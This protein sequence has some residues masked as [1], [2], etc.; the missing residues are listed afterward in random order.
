MGTRKSSWAWQV[1][2]GDHVGKVNEDREWDEAKNNLLCG[3]ENK[4][5]GFHPGS[6]RVPQGSWYEF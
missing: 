5:V 1:G 6:E 2:G 3:D 4:D